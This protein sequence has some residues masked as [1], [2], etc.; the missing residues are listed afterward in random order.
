MTSLNGSQ[1]T[2]HWNK[3]SISKSFLE[4]FGVETCKEV[5]IPVEP[6]YTFLKDK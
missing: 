1:L 6:E 4:K 5:H 3:T 2:Q